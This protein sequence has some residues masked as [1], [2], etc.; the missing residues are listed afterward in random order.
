MVRLAAEVSDVHYSVARFFLLVLLLSLPFWLLGSASD[1]QIL[2]GL[3]LSGLMV[4]VPTLSAVTLCSKVGGWHCVAGLL[5][6]AMDVRQLRRPSYLAAFFLINPMIYVASAAWQVAMG[7]NLPWADP[8]VFQALGLFLLFFL[9]ATLE[10][11]G[12]SGFATDRLRVRYGAL[13]TGLIIGSFWAAWHVWPLLQVGRSYEWIA[14]WTAGTVT[15]RTLMVWFYE[16]TGR[17]VFAMA[18]FHALSNTGWQLYPVQG[19]FYDPKLNALIT[20]TILVAVMFACRGKPHQT[21]DER[22]R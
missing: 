5:N 13:H 14:W 8:A 15:T 10:E 2:P 16:R 3:P 1:K 21:S 11:V 12:W 4:L 19:S 17:S 20:L 6:R 18:V 7:V 9:A 22:E